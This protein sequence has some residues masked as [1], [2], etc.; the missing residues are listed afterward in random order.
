[1]TL[2]AAHEMESASPHKADADV[3]T[4]IAK[5]N[6]GHLHDSMILYISVNTRPGIYYPI[7]SDR[8]VTI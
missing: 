1:M 4:E 3:T 2:C 6:A 7:N 5:R 8:K